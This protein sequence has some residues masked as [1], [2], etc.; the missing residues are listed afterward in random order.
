MQTQIIDILT[1]ALPGVDVADITR[2]YA[3]LQPHLKAPKRARVAVD[4]PAVDTAALTD[5]QLYAHYK[6]TAPYEDLAFV[7]AHVAHDET[8]TAAERLARECFDDTRVLRIPRPEFYR[9]LRS[10][11]DRWRRATAPWQPNVKRRALRMRIL[12]NIAAS[13]AARTRSRYAL[14]A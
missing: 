1:N 6:K 3:A 8:R 14:V 7:I 12:E 10:L 11:Q 9:R 2:A 13:E 5:A 4:A